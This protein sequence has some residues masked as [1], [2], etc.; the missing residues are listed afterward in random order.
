MSLEAELGYRVREVLE[1]LTLQPVIYGEAPA[2]LCHGQDD[3]G[4]DRCQAGHLAWTLYSFRAINLDLMLLTNGYTCSLLYFC[5]LECQLFR[6]HNFCNHVPFIFNI[7]GILR[8]MWA[9]PSEEG[10]QDGTSD[11]TRAQNLRGRVQG[12]WENTLGHLS[13][14]IPDTTCSSPPGASP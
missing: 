11:A 5:S 12:R 4:H 14:T 10:R 7:P 6:I 8:V 2:R 3:G 13:L 9:L 1:C